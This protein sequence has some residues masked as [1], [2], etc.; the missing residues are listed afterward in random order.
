MLNQIPYRL[1][2]A[3]RVYVQKA[4]DLCWV[5]RLRETLICQKV[6]IEAMI[7]YL[8]EGGKSRGSAMYIDPDG[9]PIEALPA[10]YRFRLDDGEHANE[11]QEIKWNDGAC[12]VQWR[13]VRPLPPEDESFEVTW[14]A[15][16]ERRFS[17]KQQ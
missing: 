8:Q 16:R 12:Y 9:D 14:K 17:A 11:V 1:K 3:E 2:E 15:Y 7:N 10:F 6:Y 5:F 13:S 4:E